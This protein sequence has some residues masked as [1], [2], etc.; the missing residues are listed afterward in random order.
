MYGNPFFTIHTTKHNLP[1][2]YGSKFNPGNYGN[3]YRQD[4]IPFRWLYRLYKGHPHVFLIPDS[5]W[6]SISHF[7]TMLRQNSFSGPNIPSGSEHL[8]LTRPLDDPSSYLIFS[9]SNTLDE[10]L[11]EQT[12]LPLLVKSSSLVPQITV[13]LVSRDLALTIPLKYEILNFWA[14]NVGEILQK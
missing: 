1:L 2:P 14:K 3:Y 8:R 4:K 12:G 9:F 6:I 10:F 5:Q 11:I 13:F 7:K